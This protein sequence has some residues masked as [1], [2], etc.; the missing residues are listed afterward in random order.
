MYVVINIIPTKKWTKI[1]TDDDINI[2]WNKS[3][4]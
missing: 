1:S 3:Y 4:W 2:L